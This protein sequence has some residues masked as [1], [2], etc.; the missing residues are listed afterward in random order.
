MSYKLTSDERTTLVTYDTIAEEWDKKYLLPRWK[1]QSWYIF[2]DS[3]KR[4]ARILDLG[5]GTA[6]QAAGDVISEGF[7]YVGIDISRKMLAVARKN[8]GGKPGITEKSLQYMDMRKLHFKDE[9]FEGFISL[10]SFMH[11]P[12]KTLPVA[13]REARRVLK[14]GG[15]GLISISRGTFEGLFAPLKDKPLLSYAVCWQIDQMRG[16]LEDVGFTILFEAEAEH[17]LVYVVERQ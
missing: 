10:T 14:P 9:T 13:L 6:S 4:G 11:L 5:C 8:L 1:D 12:R 15:R 2:V 7:E 3:M 16:L 17:M